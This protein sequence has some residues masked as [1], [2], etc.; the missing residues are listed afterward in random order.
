[1]TNLTLADISGNT[2]ARLLRTTALNRWR[3]TEEFTKVA[4][5][6][7]H[8]VAFM[9]FSVAVQVTNTIATIEHYQDLGFEAYANRAEDSV[10]ISWRYA[11]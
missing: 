10:L 8:A 7:A 9:Q 5:A 4:Q 3:E 2:A 1:M 6:V 11:K